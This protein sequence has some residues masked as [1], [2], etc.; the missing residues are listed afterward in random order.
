MTTIAIMNAKGG[1]GKST[2]TMAIAETLSV[3][4]HCRVLLV[5]ADGQMSL[6][7]MMAP[8]TLLDRAKHDHR[9]LT[10]WL[11][12]LVLEDKRADWRDYLTAPVS[13][14]DDAAN[15][16]LLAGDMDLAAL[17][18]KL[19]TPALAARLHRYVRALIASAAQ[20]FDI[21]LVDCAPGVS[22]MTECWLREADHHIVPMRADAPGGGVGGVRYLQRFPARDAAAG[23]ASRRCAEYAEF[24]D[25]QGRRH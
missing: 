15:I 11:S 18:R 9:T 14:I 7:H 3:Y 19:T 20:H 17:E 12:H 21:V 4:H 6:S 5:D 10:G 24:L 8:R 2:L 25:R 22:V 23:A 1:V 13:D 16:Y